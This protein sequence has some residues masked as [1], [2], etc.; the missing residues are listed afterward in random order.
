MLTAPG[1]RKSVRERFKDDGAL[2]M[3]VANIENPYK[4]VKRRFT[5]TLNKL[6]LWNLTA[7]DRLIYLDAD[8]LILDKRMDEL[9]SC[10]HFCAVYMNPVNFHTGLLVVK[11]NRTMFGSMLRS[12][13]TLNSYD[14]VCGAA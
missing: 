9:F 14:G 2:V 5:H 3:E 8:N 12:I 7:Y 6:H 10:G 11:P 4:H 13:G 1:V